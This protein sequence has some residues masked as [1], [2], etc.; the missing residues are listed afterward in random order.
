MATRARP[1]ARQSTASAPP[2]IGIG[3]QLAQLGAHSGAMYAERIAPLGLTPPH[4]GVLR[5]IAVQPGRNQQAIAEEFGVPASRMVAFIDDLESR[6]LVERRRDAGD[7]RVHLLHLSDDGQAILAELAAVGR[8]AERELL[9]ALSA[10]E[11][12]QLAEW[13]TR[14]ADQQGLTRGVHPGYGKLRPERDS[15]E[16]PVTKT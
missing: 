11:R 8:A 1:P 6:G 10:T 5:A 9:A 13:L 16:C 4:V 12:A 3:F 14:V 2:V 15:V 7:R